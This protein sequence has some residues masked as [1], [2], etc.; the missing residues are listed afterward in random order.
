MNALMGFFIL[1]NPFVPTNSRAER[2]TDGNRANKHRVPSGTGHHGRHCEIANAAGVAKYLSVVLVSAKRRA[3]AA[4]LVGLAAAMGAAASFADSFADSL[5]SGGSGPDMVVVPA[6]RFRMGC[7]PA[8]DYQCARGKPIIDVAIPAAFAISVHEVTFD[9]YDRYLMRTRRSGVNEA[10]DHGWG[11]G[12]RP[13]INIR[14]DHAAAFAD[15]LSDQTGHPYRLPSEA[16]WEYA[17]RAGTE[18]VW[19]WGN[20]LEA[21]RANCMDCGSPW[22][23]EQTAPVG[24]F[25]ANAWGLHDMHGNVWEMVQDCFRRTYRENPRDG[26]PMLVPRRRFLKLVADDEGRCTERILRGGAWGVPNLGTQSGTRAAW[27]TNEYSSLVG[28]RVVRE[29]DGPR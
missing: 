16:E 1:E 5:V 24:S 7:L 14:W 13:V 20:E 28:F 9:V 22:D 4:S 21:G 26:A 29:L 2:D 23:D 27:R 19:H 10:E 18:T 25:A 12:D 3:V 6:G 8:G 15:C 11:R 17:A